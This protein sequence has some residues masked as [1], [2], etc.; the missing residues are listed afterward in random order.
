[1]L[2]DKLLG[3]EDDEVEVRL[4][5]NV[6]LRGLIIGFFFGKQEI[7]EP[8][9]LKWHLV[10]KKDR[11]TLGKGVLGAYIGAIFYH[12]EVISIRFLQDNS[13]MIFK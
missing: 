10:K 12:T 7:G 13:T 4:E 8:F 1:M 6:H 5:N 11:F 3:L 9:I 2:F